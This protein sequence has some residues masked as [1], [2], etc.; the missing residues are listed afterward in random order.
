MTRNQFIMNI[1]TNRIY[2]ISLDY[3][4]LSK[5]LELALRT[6]Y[7]YIE[8][9]VFQGVMNKIMP[10][11]GTL[12]FEGLILEFWYHGTHIDFLKMEKNFIE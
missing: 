7:N 12:E 11:R 10:R 2:Q 5:K 4:L 8:D 9:S 6:K 1:D 3:Y